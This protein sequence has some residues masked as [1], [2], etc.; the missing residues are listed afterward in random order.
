MGNP[1]RNVEQKRRN[2]QRQELRKQRRRQKRDLE[3]TEYEEMEREIVNETARVIA[4]VMKMVRKRM[5]S[6]EVYHDTFSDVPVDMSGDYVRDT[7]RDLVGSKS[8]TAHAFQREGNDQVSMNVGRPDRGTSTQSN[9]SSQYENSS[10]HPNTISDNVQ[11]AGQGRG[12]QQQM[13]QQQRRQ[14]QM[15]QQQ[16]RVQNRIPPQVNSI[17]GR[18]EA[19][20]EQA[21]MGSQAL[22]YAAR[23]AGR[24]NQN[25]SNTTRAQVQ[26]SQQFGRGNT[27]QRTG[28]PGVA[29]MGGPPR[30]APRAPVA[31]APVAP[32][33]A[34][35]ARAPVAVAA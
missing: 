5:E 10:R 4:K 35:V 11:I 14:Q 26:T 16:P 19:P 32:M 25:R 6:G 3:N 30:A 9:V 34:P 33:A 23:V 29:H 21:V 17:N 1:F 15:R 13:R 8:T 22:Q 7:I 24:L 12:G 31:R 18:L 28:G 20:M 27:P 2:K